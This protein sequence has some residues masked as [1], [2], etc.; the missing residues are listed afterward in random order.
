MLERALWLHP[1][2]IKRRVFSPSDLL[3]VVSEKSAGQAG[4]YS[5]VRERE[6]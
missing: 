1:E 6:Q 3:E 4:G 2:R 5:F